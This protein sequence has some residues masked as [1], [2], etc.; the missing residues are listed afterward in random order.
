MLAA[1]DNVL[2]SEGLSP[3]NLHPMV[4]NKIEPSKF[5]LSRVQKVRI[6]EGLDVVSEFFLISHFSV[7]P[8]QAETKQMSNGGTRGS[9]GRGRRVGALPH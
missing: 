6:G 9:G 7:R 5:S 3:P 2:T 8:L 4:H 1:I